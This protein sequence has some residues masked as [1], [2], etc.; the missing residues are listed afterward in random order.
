MKNIWQGC[1]A[2]LESELTPQ[3]FNTW[4]RPLQAR[5][6]NGALRLLAPNQ[7]VLEQVAGQFQERIRELVAERGLTL[8]LE[9]GSSM[10]DPDPAPTT[11]N[12]TP[13]PAKRK[14]QAAPAPKSLM[15]EARTA[16]AVSTASRGRRRESNDAGTN[17][18]RPAAAA[19]GCARCSRRT[20]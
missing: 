5:Q 2:Q 1:V 15:E 16:R 6:A 3:L 20:S 13:G 17:R 10:V 12:G 4:I 9:I 18:K 14:R 7:F 8:M 19:T 11:A